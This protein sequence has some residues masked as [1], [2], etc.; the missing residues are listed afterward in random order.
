MDTPQHETIDQII[1]RVRG[2]DGVSPSVTVTEITGGHRVTITDASGTQTFDI[3]DGSF[4]VDDELDSTSENPAQNKVI[5]AALGNKVDKNGTDRL[6]TAAEGTKLGALPTNDALQTA[7]GGKIPA[8]EKG[9]ASGVATLDSNGKVPFAQLPSVDATPTSGSGNPVS[10]GGVY[11]ALDGKVD[12]VNGK[13]LSTEDYT[14]SEKTKLSGIATGAQVNVIET[15]KVNGTALTP[16]TNKAIDVAVPTKTSDLTNDDSVVKDASYVH[17]DN[18][19]TSAEKTKLSGIEAG[20]QVNPGVATT[21]DAG[22]MSA[23]DKAKLDGIE[24]QANKTVV[25]DALSDS[26]T[27]PVQ[28]K[29]IKAALDEITGQI[30][31]YFDGSTGE[32]TNESIFRWLNIKRDGLAY[33]VQIPKSEATAMTKLGANA[34][35]ERPTLAIGS[36]PGTDPYI[37]KSPFFWMEVNAYIDPDGTAH[38][39]AIKGDENFSRHNQTWI[40][41]P[42]LYEHIESDENYIY[43]YISDTKLSGYT[44][45]P[46]GK[47][48]N[49]NLRPFMLYAKYA[50]GYQSGGIG[51]GYAN[52]ITGLQPWCYDSTKYNVFPSHNGLISIFKT[53]ETGYSGRDTTDDWYLSTMFAMKYGT[54]NSQTYFKQCNSYYYSYA[55][56][57]AEADT[58]RVIISKA[59]AANLVLGSAVSV[60]ANRNRASYKIVSIEEYDSSNSAVNLDMGTETIT[61]DTAQQLH[62]QPWHTGACDMLETDG[63]AGSGDKYP[64]MLQGIEFGLGMYETMGNVIIKSDGST[65]WK[66]HVNKDSR[67]EATTLTADYTDTGLTLYANTADSW[68]YG[69][70][71]EEAEGMFVPQGSTGSTS[72][73]L[74]DGQYTNKL[75]TAGEREWRALGYLYV[76]GPAG[77]RYLNAGAGLGGASWDI[78]SRASANGRRG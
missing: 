61:T 78:G 55:V 34:A 28:N 36:T 47:L 25:D 18:N 22:L 16:D 37:G 74:C 27:N 8:T 46:S 69:L 39:T 59:N 35:I 17:T 10:S 41:T 71:L 45:Q 56:T 50:L 29:V 9:A 54:K 43:H 33:G 42:V 73:G 76:G 48:P 1:G 38:V 75:S 26:S 60:G 6:M 63:A 15:V 7:L 40:L 52:T 53:A 14:T 21:T 11:T 5:V 49:G 51:A 31:P 23:T 57:V 24:A 2:Q 32:Y 13:G 72:A 70:Y 62:T 3:M 65:G 30:V 44:V 66:V 19:Y 12:K 77:L 58:Q 64:A 68:K 20:A 67:K 4:F